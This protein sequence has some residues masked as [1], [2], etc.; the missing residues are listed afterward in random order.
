MK[1]V[2]LLTGP[3]PE[4]Q[5]T[6]C[7]ECLRAGLGADIEIRE[8]H[9]AGRGFIGPVSK[10]LA[11]RRACRDRDIV[12]AWGYDAFKLATLATD[13]PIFY[14]PLPGD[15]V[16]AVRWLLLAQSRRSVQLLCLS[17]GD[18][19]F[20]VQNGVSPTG[21]QLVRPGVRPA[22]SLARD[23]NLR[24][25]LGLRD[26]EVVILGLGES[27]PVAN[28]LLTL[29]AADILHSMDPKYRLILWGRGRQI[30]SILTLQ[31]H[32]KVTVAVNATRQLGRPIE[33]EELIPAANLGLLTCTERPSVFPLLAAMAGGLPVV[34]PATHSVSDILEDHHTALLYAH[35]TP[36]SV[37][38]RLLRLAEDVPLQTKLADRAR[39]EAYELFPIS[40]FVDRM[41]QLYLNPPGLI[42]HPIRLQSAD[43]IFHVQG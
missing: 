35:P 43:N 19:R 39:A 3:N 11:V 6:R 40:G 30:A 23:A 2:L 15:G 42:A 28:H 5:T 1:R 26:D 38:Q 12:H 4:L 29:R 18:E 41:R 20:F 31:D 9:I 21:T 7:C 10:V 36:K 25:L 27:E 24:R 22:R 8:Q 13:K 14:T 33:F 17:L 37:A 34:A 32:W 16:P